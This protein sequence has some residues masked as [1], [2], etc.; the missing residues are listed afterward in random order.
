MPHLDE[1]TIHAWLDSALP[2]DEA[3]SVESHVSSCEECASAVAEA[4]GLIAASSR[5][6][7]ALDAVPGGVVPVPYTR[8]AEGPGMLAPPTA[9]RW[10][11]GRP[12]RGYMAQAAAVLLLAVGLRAAWR[13][14]GESASTAVADSARMSGS[15]EA[16]AREQVEAPAS[17]AQAPMPS[18]VPRDLQPAHRSPAERDGKL[19][20]TRTPMSKRV[21][22]YGQGGTGTA[23]DMARGA[24]SRAASA[25]GQPPALARADVAAPSVT[26]AGSTTGLS[27]KSARVAE[28]RTDEEAKERMS[29]AAAGSPPLRLV[30][31]WMVV[32]TSVESTRDSVARR[33]IYEVKPAV[34]IELE[35]R[36]ALTA[37][38][39]VAGNS[40]RQTF[41]AKPESRRMR[42]AAAPSAA[43][44]AP[45]RAELESASVP[46]IHWTSASGTELT[47]R[48]PLS[49]AE[50]QALRARI[51]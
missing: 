9:A 8:A 38:D 33:T 13:S 22:G 19:A 4:R 36:L 26:V 17:T 41:A 42:D 35:E 49:A 23:H 32:S 24:P 51:P 29:T 47:L 45:P 12:W 3:A 44:A 50:L 31:G 43:P 27:M 25:G 5:I 37:T 1:G 20:Q 46:A 39:A 48:G 30:Q 11:R 2:H 28:A 34:R 7:S 6:L 18:A 16:P 15:D 21:L 14:G 40:A 10:G